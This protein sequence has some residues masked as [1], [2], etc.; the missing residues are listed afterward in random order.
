MKLKYK[1][2]ILLTTM[3]TMGIGL[4][5]LSVSHD[6]SKAE[7]SSSPKAAAEVMAENF[8]TEESAVAD[9]E[10]NENNALEEETEL[11]ETPMLAAEPSVSPTPDVT[12]VPAAL[13]VYA[14]EQEG[15]YPEIDQLIKDYYTAENNRDLKALKSLLSDPTN[16]DTQ[17]ELQQKTEYI[18]EYKSIK[19][20]TKKGY[21]EGT[22]IVYAYSEIKFTSINTPA[23]G[24][25]QFYI[26]TGD[27]GKLKIFSGEMNEETSAYYAAR[28]SDEDV[29]TLIEMTEKKSDEAKKSDEDLY[30]FWKSMNDMTNN[31]TSDDSTQGDTN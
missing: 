18:E 28:N 8:T 30:N 19:T 15:T 5:T 22:Y 10:L 7:V 27:D 25:A 16:A 31:S 11:Q 1:K 4:L 12:S 23:P 29:T 9:T 13:P 17:E 21:I 2:I 24:L 3:S 14:I 6:K 20:Y 26:I